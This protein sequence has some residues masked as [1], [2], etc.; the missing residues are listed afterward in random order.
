MDLVRMRAGLLLRRGWRATLVLAL[1]AGLAAGVAMAAL[2]TAR[3]A[4]TSLDRFLA[5]SAPADLLVNFCPPWLETIDD[6][7]LVECFS[8][9]AVDEARRAAALPEVAEAGRVRYVG[10]TA[11]AVSDPSRTWPANVLVMLDAEPEAIDGVPIIVEGR[12]PDPAA[13]DEVSVNEQFAETIGSSVGDELDLT[14]WAPEEMGMTALEGQH[15][16]G[17]RI[18]VTVV[19]VERN[20]RDLVSRVGTAIAG[21]EEHRVSA[22][23]AL[24]ARLADAGGFGG[25]A[26]VATDG[27][28]RAAEE[29]IDEAFAGRLYNLAP[30]VGADETDPVADTIGYEVAG[31]MLFGVITALAAIVFAGQ[32]VSRQS[33]REWF[34]GPTLRALGMS[35]QDAS[36]A[37][38]VRGAVTGLT[39]A[40]LAVVSSIAFATLGPFGIAGRIEI[41]TGPLVD[42]PV[43][44]AGA[45][46]VL[47]MV[48]AATWWPVAR[49][50]G[51]SAPP[52]SIS[53]RNG[54]GAVRAVL[55][56]PAAAGLSMSLRGRGGGNLPI[57]AA[58]VGVALAFAAALGAVGLTAS[59]DSFTSESA[60]FGAP[61]DLSAGAAI[62]AQSGASDLVDLIRDEPDV[63]AAA[64]IVGTDAVIGDQVAWLH[65]FQP[66]DGVD[67]RIA[68]VITEGRAPTA[69][70]EIALGA[71][72]MAD[73]GVS[74]GDSIMIQPSTSALGDES[75]VTVVGTTILNDSFENNPGRGGVVTV[76]WIERYADELSPDPYVIRLAPG[77]DVDRFRTKLEAVA[78]AGVN[79]PVLQGAIRNVERV[80]WVPFLLAGVVGVL[81]LVSLAHAL[82]LSVRRERIQ[83]AILKSLGF[84]RS[85]VFAT[86][87]CHASAIVSAAAVIG[88]PL[89]IIA[90]RWG[91]RFI[92]DEL[93][94]ASPPATPILVLSA[95]ITIVFVI[96]NLVAAYPG[97][98]AATEPAVRGLPR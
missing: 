12:T 70:D 19:G 23:P 30:N 91:W 75:R 28:L 9:D 87:A 89:G 66:I 49:Q 63:E 40:L 37:A 39:A 88:V 5:H 56:P 36:A 52:R 90:G 76:E 6:E 97:W 79:G 80:R 15:F 26:I 2:A 14:F 59:F 29:A 24:G 84:R 48:T 46:L 53:T 47:V 4:S 18:R 94:V 74:I 73:Q 78:T 35:N 96:A 45:L 60:N 38:V 67:A 68:P 64:G 69:I 77:A 86:V 10:L 7:S 34:D 55:P 44:V 21:I 92:A 13:P 17:P 22:G 1:L 72:T 51:R 81:A 50:F 57:G 82:V 98:Q 42:W 93:G 31:T 54:L 41:D 83:L 95:I 3:R 85:Q 32:A 62:N 71:T 58:I 25:V 8:Y 65:A 33:R 20:V 61:W 27:D 11:S 16:N 43:L